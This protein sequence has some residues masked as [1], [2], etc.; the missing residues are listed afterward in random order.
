[1]SIFS[2]TA[3]KSSWECQIQLHKSWM[4]PEIQGCVKLKQKIILC[5]VPFYIDSLSVRVLKNR[6]SFPNLG[7]HKKIQPLVHEQSWGEWGKVCHGFVHPSCGTSYDTACARANWPQRLH[8]AEEHK[9][10]LC[11][12]GQSWR[13]HKRRITRWY[14]KHSHPYPLLQLLTSMTEAALSSDDAPTH[15]WQ[16]WSHG[17]LSQSHFTVTAVTAPHPKPKS[18][19]IP[20]CIDRTGCGLQQLQ[21]VKSAATAPQSQQGPQTRIFTL[22]FTLP[23]QHK[24]SVPF[25][26]GEL[27]CSPEQPDITWQVHIISE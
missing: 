24:R 26:N 14:I 11:F 3:T 22:T 20:F 19:R 5:V 6:K 16:H 18:P 4:P 17:S 21:A 25:R 23:W 1:M 7:K 13:L 9:A 27:R 2:F 12:T 8:N 10:G 15:K